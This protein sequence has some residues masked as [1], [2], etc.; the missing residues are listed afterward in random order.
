MASRGRLKQP[1]SPKA[2]AT[3]GD[4]SKLL[5]YFDCSFSIIELLGLHEIEKQKVNRNALKLLE[6]SSRDSS[7]YIEL[8]N[9]RKEIILKNTKRLE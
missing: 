7:Y 5:I 3:W 1:T 8:F 4:E 6:E 9:N 2:Q